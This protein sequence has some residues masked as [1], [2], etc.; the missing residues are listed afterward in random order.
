[1]APRRQIRPLQWRGMRGM[2]LAPSGWSDGADC[3]AV[4]LVTASMY[5]ANTNT[6]IKTEDRGAPAKS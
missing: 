5:D 3:F 1:M 2:G 4:R 6:N